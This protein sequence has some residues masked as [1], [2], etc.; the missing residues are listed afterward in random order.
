LLPGPGGVLLQ[1]MSLRFASI[2]SGSNGNCYYVGNDQDAILVDAGISCREIERRMQRLGLSL[3][4]VRA[5]FISHEHSDHI[6]GLPTLLKKYRIPLYIT[7]AT[8]R[9][10]G[11]YL[12]N[13]LVRD[14]SGLEEVMIGSLRIRPFSKIHDAAD[15]YSF[16]ISHGATTVGVFTDLGRACSNLVTHFRQC[17]AAILEANYDEDLL[18]QGNYPYHLKRRIRGG[19]GHI[20]N[21]EALELFRAHRH[22]GLRHLVLGHLS[23]NNNRP[24]LVSGLFEP[25][26]EG[27]QLTVASRYEESALFHVGADGS[28]IPAHY[29]PAAPAQLQ[30][31]GDTEPA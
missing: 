4:D 28:V 16:T 13:E 9:G 19:Y 8:L 20:S 25:H 29:E 12:Y 21:R 6:R 2:N 22:S 30:L 14:F 15:P 11:M 17:H 18:E 10:T 7:P 23:Q 3:N 24:E 1:P 26:M 27:I 5:I 31:F